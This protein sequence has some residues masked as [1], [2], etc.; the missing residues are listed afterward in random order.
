MTSRAEAHV[1]RLSVLYALLDRSAV[2]QAAHLKAAVALWEYCEES[3]AYVFGDSLGDDVADTILDALRKS[4]DGLTRTEIRDL[5]QRNVKLEHIHHALAS[6]LGHKLAEQVDQPTKGR[7][8][9]IWK[10]VSTT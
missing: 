2:V 8:A 1:L 6:L 10:A 4:P 9:E 3:V 5:F 7:P